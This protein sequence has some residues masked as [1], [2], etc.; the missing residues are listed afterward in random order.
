E[1]EAAAAIDLFVSQGTQFDF[2]DVQEAAD[3]HADP[4]S[5]MNDHPAVRNAYIHAFISAAFYNATHAAV[6]HDLEGKERLLRTAQQAN[7]DIEYPGLDNFARTLPTLLRRLGLST[8]QFIVYFFVCDIC[9]KLHH[10]SELSELLSPDCT[11]ADCDGTL[12]TSKRLADGTLKRTPIKIVP[13]VPPERALQRFLLRPGKWDQFQHWRGPEDQPGHVPPIRGRGYDSFPDPSKPM[14]DIYDGYGWRMIEA[15]LERR[16]GGRWEIEDVDVHELHQRFVSLPCGL[17]WQINIDWFQAVKGKSGY[18]ST[19]AFYAVICNNPR[20]IRYL[21]EETI[22][23]MVLPGPDEPS[24]EEMNYLLEPFVES[25]LRLEKGV[26]FT[27]HGHDDPEVSHSHLYCNVSDLPS[28]RK[29]TGLQGH[30]SKFFMCPTCKT[31]SF[32]LSHPSGFDP[33]NF[34]D[35][36]DWRYIKYSFRSRNADSV[37]VDAIHENRGVRWSA[38]NYL[39]GWMPARSSVIEFMHAVFLGLVKHLNRIIL[40]KSGLLNGTRRVKP[41]DRLEAFFSGLVWPVEANRLPPSVSGSPKADQWRNQIAVLF[42]AL[43]DAWA[44]DGEIPDCDAPPSASNTKNFTAQATMQRTLRSR[45]LEHLLARNAHPSD[46]EI[47]RVNSAKMDRNLR[48]HYAVI[49]E[50]SAAVRILSSQSI[51][52]DDVHRGCAALSHATQSWARMGCHLTPYFHFVNHFEQQ[53]YEFGPCYATW[54]FAFER[55]NGKLA[56]INHNQHKGG[57]L[58]AT[59]M[60]RWWSIT[61]NYEL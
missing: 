43:Y 52:P 61:F 19:G 48:R 33:S 59:L 58:E 26:E 39:P 57:E 37:T 8:D 9:W 11:V 27:V 20:S 54:A 56:K 7:P 50:F 46:A 5:C 14:R 1:D 18:H 2:S 24:L 38:L 12:Y 25:M 40:I 21:P 28:S 49:L 22:L 44:V 41:M 51:S 6:Y 60:R 35:R 10:P 23:V 32:S 47:D 16:R 15:G 3:I 42:V 53:M 55:H 17:V 30:S 4:P 45:L 36:D 29:V 31:P 13:Y 34:K